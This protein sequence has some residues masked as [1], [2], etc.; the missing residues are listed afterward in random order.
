MAI[1]LFGIFTAARG[2]VVSRTYCTISLKLKTDEVKFNGDEKS[3]GV[4][5]LDTIDE[6]VQA[7]RITPALAQKILFNYD[8]SVQDNIKKCGVEI[9]MKAKIIDYTSVESIYKFNLK[10]VVITKAKE[11]RRSGNE[12]FQFKGPLHVLAVGYKAP[13]KTTKKCSSNNRR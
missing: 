2:I 5:L 9:K 6:L 1:P 12:L 7:G 13:G 8:V 3:V 11:G 10:D 4:A